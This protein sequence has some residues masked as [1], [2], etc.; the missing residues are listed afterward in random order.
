[1]NVGG[2]PVRKRRVCAPC[3]LIQTAARFSASGPF[4]SHKL[5]AALGWAINVRVRTTS[6]EMERERK[7]RKNTKAFYS[8][9]F[10]GL[11]LQCFQKER[12]ALVR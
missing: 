8:E 1:M 10:E 4:L 7:R 3:A 12:Q 6:K 9:S 5:R 11:K 2:S